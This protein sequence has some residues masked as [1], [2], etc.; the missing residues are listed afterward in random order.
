MNLNLDP[1]ILS[2]KTVVITGGASG[3]GEAYVACASAAGANVVF[4]DI[5]ETLGRQVAART[6]T[7]FV[8]TDVTI[9]AD[10]LRLFEKAAAEFGT[11][12]H[13]IA[14]A[15]IFDP[16]EWFDSSLSLE[17]VQKEPSS[18]IFDVN[19]RG[20]TMFAH[21]ASVYLRQANQ[22]VQDRSLTLVSSVAAIGG[23]SNFP[24]YAVGRHCRSLKLYRLLT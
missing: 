5:D 21:L 13:A 18:Q 14:N 11:I 6:G 22:D 8:R 10:Q 17:S 9:Y 12:D 16:R 19:I 24:L 7:I 4:G 2:G 20:T 1:L 23:P 3:I 15:G